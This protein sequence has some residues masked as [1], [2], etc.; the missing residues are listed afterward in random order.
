M[1]WASAL[2]CA[3]CQLGRAILTELCRE[4]GVHARQ[5][6]H[7]FHFSSGSAR[8]GK[9][10][11]AHM[12][13]RRLLFMP[14]NLP[15]TRL[16]EY[17]F[18]RLEL[19]SNYPMDKSSWA[20][21]QSRITDCQQLHTL[22]QPQDPHLQQKFLPLRLINV[23]QD[24]KSSSLDV[25]LQSSMEIPAG[26]NYVALSYC[27]GSYESRCMTT[28]KTLQ[29]NLQR[30]EW[31]T[32]PATFRDAVA[33]TRGLGINYLWIDSMCIVQNDK[34]EWRYESARMFHV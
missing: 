14:S 27:W 34:D 8:M 25:K 5:D 10:A 33:F 21:A 19:L 7:F 2:I 6:F 32:L 23:E 18:N 22:C 26:S 1:L 20:W 17:G 9:I 28:S 31:Y 30:I 13:N 11:R 3:K 12:D 15:Y 4:E 16:G 29:K 24:P